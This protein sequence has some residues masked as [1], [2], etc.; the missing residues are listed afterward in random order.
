MRPLSK[1]FWSAA[2]C[3]LREVRVP[4]GGGTEEEGCRGATLHGGS[5]RPSMERRCGSKQM[6]DGR[7]LQEAGDKGSL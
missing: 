3:S 6:S 4:G 1:R 7:Y 2:S 5:V